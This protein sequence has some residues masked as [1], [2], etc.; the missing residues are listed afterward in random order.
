M[1]MHDIIATDLKKAAMLM[2]ICAKESM[3][4]VSSAT[5]PPSTFFS[6]YEKML[7]ILHQ[8]DDAETLKLVN[9]LIRV[10]EMRNQNGNNQ[11]DHNLN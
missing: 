8:D 3:E 1:I 7:D 6:M 4:A 2:A 11:M 10:Y 5:V 9:S